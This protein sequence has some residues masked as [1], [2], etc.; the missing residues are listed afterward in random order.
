MSRVRFFQWVDM[1]VR[2]K[3]PDTRCFNL[4]EIT[5]R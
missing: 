4:R 2:S 5:P 1:I 3:R